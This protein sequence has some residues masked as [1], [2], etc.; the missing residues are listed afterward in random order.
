V[1]SIDDLCWRGILSER[2][3]G[4]FDRNDA[5]LFDRPL[6]APENHRHV[7]RKIDHGRRQHAARAAVEH[8]IDLVL[9]GGSCGVLSSTVIDLTTDVPVVLRRGKGPVEK[10]GVVPVESAESAL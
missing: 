4:A 10:L 9:D 7:G 1:T 3:L 5:E 2:A 8:E 6:A